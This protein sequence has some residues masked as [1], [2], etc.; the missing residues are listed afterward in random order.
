MATMD[1]YF[2]TYDYY[3]FGSTYDKITIAKGGH[4]KHKTKHDPS[5]HTRKIVTNIQNSEKKKARQRLNSV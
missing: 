1:D 5:G 4:A 2:D 3:N